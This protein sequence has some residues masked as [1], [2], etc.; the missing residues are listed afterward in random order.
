MDV[1]VESKVFDDSLITRQPAFA[2]IRDALFAFNEGSHFDS[3]RIS[4]ACNLLIVA[5]LIADT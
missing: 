5:L 1:Y 2:E 3:L 4:G